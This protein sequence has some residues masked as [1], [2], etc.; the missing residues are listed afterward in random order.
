MVDYKLVTYP[1]KIGGTVLSFPSKICQGENNCEEPQINLCKLTFLFT[2][3]VDGPWFMN[4]GGQNGLSQ[5]KLFVFT[6]VDGLFDVVVDQ[7]PPKVL[8]SS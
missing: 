6:T 8:I 7:G 3:K 1:R 4:H 2:S 5:L